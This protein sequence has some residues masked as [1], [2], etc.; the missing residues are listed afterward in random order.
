MDV[1]W[2]I[3]F[4]SKDTKNYT[5]QQVPGS[6]PALTHPTAGVFV[7]FDGNLAAGMDMKMKFN[8]S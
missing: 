7:D 3:F 1:P 4:C 6:L 2:N 8:Y 5:V